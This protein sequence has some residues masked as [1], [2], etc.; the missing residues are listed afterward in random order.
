MQKLKLKQ[1]KIRT[2]THTYN[3]HHESCFGTSSTIYPFVQ[4]ASLA[5]VYC[6]KASG[7][8][9]LA[10]TTLSILDPDQDS[11]WIFSCCPVS[12]RSYSFRS[13]GLVPS[14]A[15]EVYGWG[16]LTMPWSGPP[17]FVSSC[18]SVPCLLNT[19]TLGLGFY[20]QL[21]GSP[22]SSTT[23]WLP[24]SNASSSTEQSPSPWN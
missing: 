19:N 7:S 13:A 2:H 20:W 17:R 12:W 15:L 18:I 3:S 5:N 24:P 23:N 10:T 14:C 11:S 9:P 1:T 22:V 4:T 21:S 16:G 6:N 8:R